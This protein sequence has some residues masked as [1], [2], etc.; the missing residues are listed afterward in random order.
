MD[1]LSD[2]LYD[3]LISEWDAILQTAAPRARILW[4]SGGLDTSTYLDNLPVKL[5]AQ[6]GSGGAPQVMSSSHLR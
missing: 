5:N 4:R 3:A 1:W 2:K 6:R